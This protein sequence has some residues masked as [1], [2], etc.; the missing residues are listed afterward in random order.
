[1]ALDPISAVLNIGESLIDKLIPDKTAA[2]AAKA[3]LLTMQ[4]Q[5]EL[6]QIQGQLEVDKVEAASN[7]T[8]V[9]GWRPFI[10]WICGLGLGYQFL[11]RPFLQLGVDLGGSHAVVQS[12]DLGTLMT[13]LFGILG[14]GAMR[15]VDK[16]N[17]V[18]NGH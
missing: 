4:T 10:G 3:S 1:M 6:A 8:F 2:A 5:G 12:L 14:L 15:T 7:S 17:G 18:G 13:L 9:A 11:A 16:I